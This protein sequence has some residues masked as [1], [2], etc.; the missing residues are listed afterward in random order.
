MFLRTY[1]VLEEVSARHKGNELVV[2]VDDRQLGLLAVKQDL[3]ALVES[4]AI[5]SND[6]VLAHH[7][8]DGRLGVR[9]EVDVA[10]RNDADKLAVHGAVLGDG[11]AAEAVLALDAAHVLDRGV[12]RQH[13]GVGDETV[14][15]ALHGV[16][17]RGL[18][19]N[20][21][22]VVDDAE[23]ALQRHGDGH[24]RLSHG[25]HGRGNEGQRELDVARNT[26]L[27]RHDLC[28]EV[29]MT[30][31]EQEVVVGVALAL[32]EKVLGAEAVDEVD[33]LEGNLGHVGVRLAHGHRDRLRLVGA[34]L[35]LVAAH[36]DHGLQ[37]VL[38]LL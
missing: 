32:G 5:L 6:E 15:V 36:A 29:N 38:G 9:H 8:G 28:A 23:T 4:V 11:D 20:G 34:L 24:A 17:H 7:L 30:R 12:G 33:G 22:V 37:E 18:L 35:G 10:V 31:H 3:V 21:A 25:V 1:L 19:R 16:D 2:L 27:K 26:G 13:L 14:L